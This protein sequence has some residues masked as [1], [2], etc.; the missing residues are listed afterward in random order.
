[1]VVGDLG[2]AVETRHVAERT[3]SMGRIDAIIHNAGMS[4]RQADRR[5]ERQAGTDV[6]TPSTDKPLQINKIRPSVGLFRNFQPK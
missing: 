5:Y 6:D 1:V 3:S 4:S 2:S